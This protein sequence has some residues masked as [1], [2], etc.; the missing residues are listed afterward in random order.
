MKAAIVLLLA[1]LAAGCFNADDVK[2]PADAASGTEAQ[3]CR[4]NMQMLATEVQAARSNSGAA[5]YSSF[6]GSP[7]P[8]IGLVPT[9]PSGGSYTIEGG[10]GGPLSFQVRCTVHGVVER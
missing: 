8:S 7:S 2:T 3:T 9:C 1:I 6:M 5:D 10:S 4:S